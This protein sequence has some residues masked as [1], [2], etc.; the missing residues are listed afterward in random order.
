MTPRRAF[1]RFTRSLRG[2]LVL[3][4]TVFVLI[5][6]LVVGLVVGKMFERFVHG[7]VEARLEAQ[8]SQIAQSLSP[9]G[10]SF[11]PARN[12][13]SWDRGSHRRERSGERAAE[14]DADI[15]APVHRRGRPGDLDRPPF[16]RP[17]SGWYWQ[18]EGPDGSVL[19]SAS[20]AS[21]RLSSDLAGRAEP[22]GRGGHSREAAAR[23]GLIVKSRE[24]AGPGGTRVVIVATAP[25]AA[26]SR[27]LREAS[28]AVALPIGL[29]G[30]LL[31]GAIA[32]QVRFGLAPLEALRASLAAVRNGERDRL[33]EV[34]AS[35]L[36][37]LVEELNALI[38]QDAAN[39][40]Q[41][42]RHVANLA[43]GLKTPL[44][45]L[46]AAFER[47]PDAADRAD[48]AGSI[49]LMDRR[50]RH[51]LRRARAAA[52]DGHARYRTSLASHAADIAAVVGRLRADDEIGI[53]IAIADDALV[54]VEP[55]DL[56]E[57]LGNL[58]DN[59]ARHAASRVRVTAER[60]DRRIILSIEDDGAGLTDAE[61]QAV[62]QPGRRLD[63]TQPGHGFGLPITSELA[64]LYGGSLRLR[65][66]ASGGLLA[67]L[68]LPAAPASAAA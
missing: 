52:L 17:G 3:S 15:D 33:P 41:A 45:T 11:G 27:P 35:E 42:R 60:E 28:F 22:G 39:L 31:V 67:Q 40:R 32:L 50:I 5:S 55:E 38:A 54:A 9:D 16:D 59:A 34:D 68:T 56:D 8:I 18:V 53:D 65:R 61:T 4:A 25:D 62:L 14:R 46:S 64:E 21:E 58:L 12:E 29:C 23:A 2:R 24:I 30:L 43:H 44:A 1:G 20:L 51:H 63:E 48:L 7:E 19:R 10:R 26:V 36:R 49:E 66:G 13:A 37:P 57:M 47:L 6:M